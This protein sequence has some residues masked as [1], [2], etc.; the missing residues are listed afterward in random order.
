MSSS[1]AIGR[2]MHRAIECWYESRMRGDPEPD[3]DAL[4]TAFWDE[5]R[6]CAEEKSV[7]LGKNESVSSIDG[8]ARR[9]LTSFVGSPASQLEGRIIGIEEEVRGSVIE[10]VPD[11]LGRVDL[12]IESET[13]VLVV[14]WKTSRSRWSDLQTELSSSQLLM[15]GELCRDMVREKPIQLRYG[16]IAKTKT[17]TVELKSVAFDAQKVDRTKA[18]IKHAWS[19]IEQGNFYPCPS[20]MNCCSCPYRRQCDAWVG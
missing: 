13:N 17:P 6:C 18:M 11:F 4:L 19:A 12:V 7:T 2:A 9:V 8:L 10:G 20:T 3:A 1:L 15:Y 14:D 5:W 16:V